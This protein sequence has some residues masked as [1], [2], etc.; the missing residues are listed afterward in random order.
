MLTESE[1]I[2]LTTKLADILLYFKKEEE[3]YVTTKMYDKS[4]KLNVLLC[5]WKV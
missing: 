5:V 2:V 1:S 3:V 4:S